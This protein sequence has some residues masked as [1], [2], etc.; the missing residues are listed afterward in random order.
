MLSS[1]LFTVLEGMISLKPFDPSFTNDLGQMTTAY[2]IRMEKLRLEWLI[3]HDNVTEL[4]TNTIRH[5]IK[6]NSPSPQ[7]RNLE[8]H[9]DTGTQF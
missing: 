9:L 4:V 3:V 1:R 5:V 6:A 8:L 7:R 2:Q